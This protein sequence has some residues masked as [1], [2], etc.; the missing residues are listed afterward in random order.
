MDR[1]VK[2]TIFLKN[3]SAHDHASLLG[4]MGGNSSRAAVT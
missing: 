1:V 3:M 4:I 2:T